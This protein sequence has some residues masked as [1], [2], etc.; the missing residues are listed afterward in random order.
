MGQED[1]V[2]DLKLITEKFKF[3][4]YTQ[5][6]GS[7]I[8]VKGGNNMVIK[9]SGY[10]LEEIISKDGFV[11]LDYLE[12]RDGYLSDSIKSQRD[13]N[14]VV[15]KN[16]FED[17]KLKRVKPSI[18]TG[19]HSFMK[20]YVVHIHPMYLNLLLCLKET[21]K[22]L[23]ELYKNY[24]FFIID[25]FK[26]GHELCVEVLKGFKKLNI[27]ECRVFFLKNHGLIVSSDDI[28][29]II[30][31]TK[32]I[33]DIAKEFII[34]KVNFEHEYLDLE[35]KEDSFV[36]SEIS[37][38]GNYVFPDAIVFLNDIFDD[39]CLMYEVLDD[40]VIYNGDNLNLFRNVD[41]ILFV[42]NF[43]LKFGGMFGTLNYLSDEQISNILGMDEEK[44]R[45][46]LLSNKQN[47]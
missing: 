46:R 44:Y 4:E 29:E 42:H 25:Y 23:N 38:A 15:S 30:D 19:F 27:S 47:L 3:I 20:K 28:D 18:E 2:K 21:D 33:C 45:K 31:V 37:N 41:E 32:K 7:N 40:K 16:I 35:V 43:I 14:D 12:L 39:F 6:T 13:S 10:T 34:D 9:A 24:N 26:P 17:Y 8:S 11:E 22:I 5:G 36:G 1:L